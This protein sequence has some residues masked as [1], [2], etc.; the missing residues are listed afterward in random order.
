MLPGTN[1]L[2][3][4]AAAWAKRRRGW[5]WDHLAACHNPLNFLRSIASPGPAHKWPTHKN[6]PVNLLRR[7]SRGSA[8]AWPAPCASRRRHGKSFCSPRAPGA[9]R[10]LPTSL[11]RLPRRLTSP[12]RPAAPPVSARCTPSWSARMPPGCCSTWRA[13]T[14]WRCVRRR[15][16]AS[17]RH[18]PRPLASCCQSSSPL[19]CC[20]RPQ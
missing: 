7:T 20:R 4:R 14:W 6:R 16:P 19:A 8:A 13:R 9:R 11:G 15:C 2:G 3:G 1:Q 17:L 12:A 18:S 5:R 10:P